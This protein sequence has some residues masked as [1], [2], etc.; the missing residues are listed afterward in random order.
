MEEELDLEE[1]HSVQSLQSSDE[2]EASIVLRLQ[3]IVVRRRLQSRREG[4]KS[5]G[6]LVQKKQSGRP[7]KRGWI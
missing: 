4:R 7:S 5:S 6:R 3:T 1:H 2:G